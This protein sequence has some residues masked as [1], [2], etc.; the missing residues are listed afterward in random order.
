ME[1]SAGMQAPASASSKA[2]D[3]VKFI[4]TD[5]YRTKIRVLKTHLIDAEER[6]DALER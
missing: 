5:D 4:K 6:I 2:Q 3:L 1:R